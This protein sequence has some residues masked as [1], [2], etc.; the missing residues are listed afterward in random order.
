MPTIVVPPS[1]SGGV[2]PPGTVTGGVP[3]G[4]IAADTVTGGTGA[5]SGNIAASTIGL[6]NLRDEAKPDANLLSNP[7]FRF[8]QL[9]DPTGPFLPP[10]NTVGFDCWRQ[11]SGDGLATPLATS[12]TLTST[13]GMNDGQYGA[14]YAQIAGGKFMVF[15]ALEN[16]LT[17][18]VRGMGLTFQFQIKVAAPT[19]IRFGFVRWTG[20]AN[21]VP[22]PVAAWNGPGVDPTLAAGFSYYFMATGVLPGAGVFQQFVATTPSPD[23]SNLL[24]VVFTDIAAFPGAGFTL[25]GARLVTGLSSR[26]Y[27]PLSAVEDLQRVQRFI[28]KS[29][30]IDTI[31]GAATTVGQLLAPAMSIGAGIPG[32]PIVPLQRKVKVPVVILYSPVTGASGNWRQTGVGDTV[33]TAPGASGVVNTNSFVG[34]TTPAAGNALAG[35]F[36][37]NAS[38]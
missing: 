7:S 2:I 30:D 15:Q 38:L 19:T 9:F 24:L 1:T 33:T 8:A 36:V 35:H 6:Y 23:C 3:G 14:T 12:R 22:M 11:L 31:P 21:V 17:Q 32:T 5:G 4:M 10:D 20:A 25:A 37:A 26:L 18:D 16:A 28:E 27:E 13:L 34:T 29:Y